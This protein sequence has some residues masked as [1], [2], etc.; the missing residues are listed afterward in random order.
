MNFYDIYES[1]AF[2]LRYVGIIKGITTTTGMTPG[3]VS[4]SLTAALVPNVSDRTAT[5]KFIYQFVQ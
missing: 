4:P 3:M 5:F 2:I 1:C